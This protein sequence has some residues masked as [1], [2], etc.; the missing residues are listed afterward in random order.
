MSRDPLLLDVIAE[1][2]AGRI[3]L[4]PIRDAS[5]RHWLDGMI[6]GSDI[7]VNPSANVV[8]T[9]VHECLHRM[10]PGWTER[11]VRRRTR[12][13]LAQL[14][15]E[16]VERLYAIILGVAATRRRPV[17]WKERE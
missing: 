11:G 4:A 14:S 7:F 5:N 3:Y 12:Q 1:I 16:E 6:D 10:K 13:L 8:D 17:I 15:H 9:V 2:G